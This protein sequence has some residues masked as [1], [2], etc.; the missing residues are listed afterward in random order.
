M[1]ERLRLASRDVPSVLRKD[2]PAFRFIRPALRSV[3][4]AL[5]RVLRHVLR[6]PGLLLA[7]LVILVALA[8]AVFPSAFTGQQPLAVGGAGNRLAPPG[9]HH[10]F[11][12]DQLGRDVYAR[13]VYGTGLTLR[14]A[15]LALA[16]A[17]L[18]GTVLGLTAG[19]S[20]GRVDDAVMRLVD[21]LL[22]VP[23][24]LLSL[25]VV[26]ALGFGTMKVA[27]AVGV[28]AIASFARVVRVQALRVRSAP[29]VEAARSFGVRRITV[30]FRHVLPAT[31]AP[32]LVLAT[33]E[34][35]VAIL[36]VS[37]LSFLG[38]GARPPTPEWGSLVASGRGSMASAW[39][40][41]TMPGLVIAAVVLAANRI[42]REVR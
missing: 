34:F 36:A 7:V 15:A 3:R 5:S 24:L 28:A 9:A 39:W 18:A 23:G 8:A 13:V 11:G 22:A 21:V 10:L 25:A 30:V 41:T 26:T 35:G 32:V 6:R 12:T 31:V 29:Y 40:L 37:S 1:S 20:G 14:A 2:R 16:V 42:A 19:F 38:F 4:P 33:L 27:L 17:V